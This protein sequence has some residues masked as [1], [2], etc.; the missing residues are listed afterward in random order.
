MLLRSTGSWTRPRS[1][2]SCSRRSA[3]SRA[4]ALRCRRSAPSS[5]RVGKSTRLN[6]SYT[7]I[8][9]LSL[10]DASPIYGIVDK[11]AEP[12]ELFEAIRIVARGGAA[13]PALGPEQL[14]SREEHTSELQLHLY[15]P[16]FP[17]RC[18]SDLRDR[19]QGRG[20]AGA[21]RGDP[22]R[23]ARRRCAAGARPRAAR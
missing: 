17:T 9:P 21:V 10:H 12:Q 15:L 3:S 20:A 22:H 23:R 14:E 4:A 16:S 1:R 6:S 13:L 11:A 7:Y 5:S 2:R 19:G 18:F 8:Y